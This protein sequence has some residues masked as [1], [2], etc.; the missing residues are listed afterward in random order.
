[1]TR[2]L[3]LDI[4]DWAD[5]FDSDAE[6]HRQFD[7]V[8]RAIENTVPLV[9]VLA[10]GRVA[11]TARGPA[12]YYRSEQGA[13]DALRRVHPNARIGIADGLFTAILAA[14]A[15]N[16][17]AIVPAG[18]SPAFLSPLSVS[19][20]GEPEI[21]DLLLRL[22]VSTLGAFAALDDVSVRDR[23]GFLGERLHRYARGL[24]DSPIVPR[25]IPIDYAHDT[26]FDPAIVRA[27]ELAF[28]MRV[29]A[30]EFI[31]R[32]GRDR[33][34]CTALWVTLTTERGERFER[35]WAHP[36]VFAGGDI[37]DRIRWQLESAARLTTDTSTDGFA[38]DGI[39]RVRLAPDQLAPQSRFE[40]GM[41]G[42]PS[43]D[44]IHSVL[45]R[46]QSI[47]GHDGVL[48]ATVGGGRTLIEREILSPWGDK[49][50]VVHDPAKPWPGALPERLP[51]TVYRDGVVVTLLGE[52]AIAPADVLGESPRWIELDK[53]RRE[54]VAWSGPWPVAERWWDGGG[55]RYRLQAVDTTGAAWVLLS[56]GP[57]WTVEARYD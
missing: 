33:L 42:A 53:R 50:V 57:D 43:S 3:V 49:P 6:S 44:R 18:D 40:R 13:A 54:I 12:R 17:V 5:Q 39:V 23:F 15:A 4:P 51:T 36:T 11:M 30:D 32:I 41:W 7:P 46:V 55:I 1:M 45:S 27:D 19:H 2:V 37:V 38:G 26:D 25:D 35:C 10:A 21:V 28:A 9:R 47:L 52:A 29:T 8:I 24:D 34:A 16:P 22:G 20:L 31:D 14:R 48:T 56:N